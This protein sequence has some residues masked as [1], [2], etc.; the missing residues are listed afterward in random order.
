MCSPIWR[1]RSVLQRAGHRVTLATSDSFT[2]WIETYGVN[3]HPTS[4]NMQAALQTP[5]AQAIAKSNNYLHQVRLLRDAM[6]QNP[7]ARNATWD[8]IQDAPLVWV[9]Q[10]TMQPEHVSVWLRKQEAPKAASGLLE[11]KS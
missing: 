7:E 9:V 1:W 3:I 4:F 11:R 10:E 2:P 5:E 8:A 6:R